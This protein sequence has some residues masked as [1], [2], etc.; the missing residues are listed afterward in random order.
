MPIRGL[1]FGYSEPTHAEAGGTRATSARVVQDAANR[2][3]IELVRERPQQGISQ[4]FDQ[5]SGLVNQ[6]VQKLMGS[7]GDHDDVVQ[8][9]FC[10]MIDSIH[11]VR[12]PEKLEAW[13]RS[14]TVNAVL[15]ELRRQRF[16]RALLRRAPMPSATRN[17]VQDIETRDLLQ[18][19]QAL[20][21]A[22]PAGERIVFILHHAESRTLNEVAELCGYSLATAKRR[23]ARA[24]QRFRRLAA[25]D[26]ELNR[27]VEARGKQ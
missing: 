15:Q 23:L 3:L 4:L 27:L 24:N 12:E 20:L 21:D 14:V 10:A 22:M 6:W 17:F 1:A 19:A 25:R 8:A 7:D 5:F 26:N 9:V 13:V 11:Q 18:R 16:R 2:A